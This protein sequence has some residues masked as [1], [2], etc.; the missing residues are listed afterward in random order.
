MVAP[1]APLSK[2]SGA[3]GATEWNTAPQAL[4][5]CNLTQR[6]ARRQDFQDGWYTGVEVGRVQLNCFPLGRVQPKADFSSAEL[7]PAPPNAKITEKKVKLPC[8][9]RQKTPKNAPEA[10]K[11]MNKMAPKAPEN[12]EKWPKKSGIFSG[13]A[14]FWTGI[15]PPPLISL[16]FQR[17]FAERGGGFIL[18]S[19]DVTKKTGIFGQIAASFFKSHT[20]F[21]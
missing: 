5:D 7:H 1:Q 15:N 6:K 8:W 9:R 19:S 11:K 21:F 14:L 13:F 12:F 2:N 20:S 10:P 16:V 3:A 18:F 17:H 4:L